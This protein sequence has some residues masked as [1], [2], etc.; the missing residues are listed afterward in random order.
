[1]HVIQGGDDD[2]YIYD[3]H[4]GGIAVRYYV[5]RSGA[6]LFPIIVYVVLQCYMACGLIV[7]HLCVRLIL[8]PTSSDSIGITHHI[9]GHHEQPNRND[10]YR[11]PF[12]LAR[13]EC[14]MQGTPA[15]TKK[16]H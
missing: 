10:H 6:S 1:M 16:T 3:I 8:S 9:L 2:I 7:V 12:S 15:S 5:S 11:F 14:R 13:N 4:C